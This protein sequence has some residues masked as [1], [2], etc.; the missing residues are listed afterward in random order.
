MCT[1]V[2]ECMYMWEPLEAREDRGSLE[3]ELQVVWMRGS[4]MLGLLGEQE[5]FSTIEPSSPAPLFEFSVCFQIGR[6]SSSLG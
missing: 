2:Y 3:L 6:D 1:H 5:A 4:W